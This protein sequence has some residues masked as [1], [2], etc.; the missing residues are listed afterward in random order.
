MSEFADKLKG[1]LSQV[2]ES[3]EQLTKAGRGLLLKVTQQSSQQF[4]QL[5]KTGEAHQAGGESLTTQLKTSLSESFSGDTKESLNQLRLAALGLVT[6]AKESGEKYF[7][8]LVQ[9]GEAKAK[10]AQ[11][12]TKAATTTASSKKSGTTAAA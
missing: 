3:L 7:E 12:K 2:N 8:E 11:N 6:K 9:L 1:Q 5:V 10:P 4:Q